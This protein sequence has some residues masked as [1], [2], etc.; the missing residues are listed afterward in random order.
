MRARIGS[1]VEVNFTAYAPHALGALDYRL[2]YGDGTSAAQSTVPLICID[3]R[4]IPARQTWRLTHRYKSAGR[5]RVS[6]SVYVN[7]TNAH[8]TASVTVIVP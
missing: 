6:V 1:P 3:G 5:Y 7:C 8:A 2:R 4:R